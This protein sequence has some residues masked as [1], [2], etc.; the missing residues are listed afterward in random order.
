[1]AVVDYVVDG[2]LVMDAFAS[3][4]VFVV[5]F[6]HQ[7]SASFMQSYDLVVCGPLVSRKV[8]PGKFGGWV[9]VKILLFDAC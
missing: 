9:W 1:M 8:K 3:C 4:S 7:M 5:L 2:V 6:V